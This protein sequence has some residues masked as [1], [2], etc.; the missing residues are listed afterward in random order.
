M[1]KDHYSQS[2]G[3]IGRRGDGMASE[4]V[5]SETLYYAF[6]SIARQNRY[7]GRT[8]LL[9]PG[10]PIITERSQVYIRLQPLLQTEL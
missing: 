9:H 2:N 6:Q 1:K 8:L 5:T 10:I 7:P 3:T 4:Q